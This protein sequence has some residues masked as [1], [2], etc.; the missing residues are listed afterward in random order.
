M[1]EIW[2]PVAG[3]RQY[4]ISSW[5]RVRNVDQPDR[6]LKPGRRRHQYYFVASSNGRHRIYRLDKLVLSTFD[7]AFDR[8]D[9][10]WE[11][12]H[13]DG[14][15]ANCALANLKAVS[16]RD[17]IKFWQDRQVFRGP[18][19]LAIEMCNADGQVIT[20]FKGYTQ[21]IRFLQDHGQLS[22]G[23]QTLRRGVSRLFYALNRARAPWRELYGYYWRASH[24]ADPA[25][26]EK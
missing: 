8:H 17:K 11:I 1:A 21:A 14:D 26:P 13:V 4:E 3:E 20:T 18:K 15:E 19:S 6:F 12:I 10:N 5:G 25:K 16:R 7:P 23:D 9:P 2:L 22:Q 24:P